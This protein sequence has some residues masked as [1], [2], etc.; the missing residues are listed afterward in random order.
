MNDYSATGNYY[1]IGHIVQFSGLSDRTIRSYIASGLLQGEKIN[2]LW[3]FTPEQV[4]MFMSHPMVR[5][6]IQAKR[7]AIVSDFLADNKKESP[8]SCMILDLPGTN[9]EKLTEYFNHE[10]MNGEFQKFRFSLD[11]AGSVP[12]VFLSGRTGELLVLVNRLYSMMEGVD[13]SG[14][15]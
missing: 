10:I 15:L 14:T 12:R 1:T 5:P 8:Q 6:S 7:N 3:H 4:E 11:C 9:E 2:G 13:S